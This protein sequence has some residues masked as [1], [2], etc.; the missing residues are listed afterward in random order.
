[1]KADL[2]SFLDIPPTHEILI[3]QGDSTLWLYCPQYN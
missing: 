3:M 2:T 1:M